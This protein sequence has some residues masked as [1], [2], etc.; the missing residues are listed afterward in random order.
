MKFTSDLHEN[1]NKRKAD[2]N[3][4]EGAP[5]AKEQKIM[6][7]PRNLHENTITLNFVKRGWEE[8]APG[9]LYYLPLCQT[10]KY[11]FD[12]AMVNQFRKFNDM[13]ETMEII[14]P[15]CKVTNL[16]MLQDDL[17]VQNSTPTDATAFTQVVYLVKYCPK[18]LK[19]YFKLAHVPDTKNMT[20]T[21]TLTYKLYPDAIEK[22]KYTQLTKI[23]GFESFDNLGILPAKANAEAGFVPNKQQPSVIPGGNT[24]ADPY[25]APNAVDPLNAL[26]GNLNTADTN[27][28]YQSPGNVITLAQNQDKIEFY[29]YG[30]HF[31]I[32]ITT[33]LEGAHLVN[34]KVN[35]FLEETQLN[36]TISGKE[37]ALATEWAYPS[38]NRPY[39][40]RQNYFDKNTDPITAGKKFKNLEHCFICMPPI[41]KPGGELLGQRCSLFM[42]QSVT[43]R[44]HCSQAIFDNAETNDNE[45][46]VHQDNQ[47]VI[48]RNFYPTPVLISGGGTG[49]PICPGDSQCQTYSDTK[50]SKKKYLEKLEKERN[51]VHKFAD[52]PCVEDSWD[53]ITSMI[54]ILTDGELKSIMRFSIEY[55]T[56]EGII[57]FKSKS[58]NF[59]LFNERYFADADFQTAWKNGQKDGVKIFC[60]ITPD[61]YPINDVEYAYVS[62]DRI[63]EDLPF[64]ISSGI[65]YKYFI[66]DPTAFRNLML[67]K[68]SVVCDGVRTQPDAQPAFDKTASTFFV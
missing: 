6:P 29:K 3:G 13:W 10:P 56:E 68:S 39:L 62:L 44:F 19:Q 7:I 65:L 40:C 20:T 49:G 67:T 16:I 21:K 51:K 28:N 8:I 63:N 48:R 9:N 24:I 52:K 57:E 43:I 14:N 2:D 17:R 59:W 26:S 1:S 50:T 35:D 46:Q 18:G 31:E 37:Y 53:K 30:D 38:R 34:R 41:R 58:T 25:I 12:Q 36:I 45:L 64:T 22:N 54:D 42:E 27:V 60:K 47:V 55:P 11:M 4:P 66:I 5:A 32:P 61:P 15:Q 33:N 23:V